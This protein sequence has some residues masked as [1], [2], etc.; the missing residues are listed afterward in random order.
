MRDDDREASGRAN[1]RWALH[2]L[3]DLRDVEVE[4]WANEQWTALTERILLKDLR[5]EV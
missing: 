5:W 2:N 3:S 4:V 1:E